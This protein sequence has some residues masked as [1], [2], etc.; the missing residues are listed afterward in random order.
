M[1]DRR[2]GEF[3]GREQGKELGE[4]LRACR[5]SRKPTPC[6]GEHDQFPV[7]DVERIPELVPTVS[8]LE[9]GVEYG[10]SQH[11]RLAAVS[12][13]AGLVFRDQSHY[14]GE[15][16]SGPFV[17]PVR[18]RR[19]RPG[20]GSDAIVPDT[21]GKHDDGCFD[22]G[23]RVESAFDESEVVRFQHGVLP[24]D[25]G[26]P[27]LVYGKLELVRE[28]RPRFGYS[29][30]NLN[31]RIREEVPCQIRRSD[32]GGRTSDHY[33][34]GFL[35]RYGPRSSSG[36]QQRRGAPPTPPPAPPFI[37][38]LTMFVWTTGLLM[39]I[40]EAAFEAVVVC[41]LPR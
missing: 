1:E 25:E 15:D 2:D 11:L 41:E 26:K 16:G 20:N 4:H 19:V 22:L 9:H 39:K 27:P 35:E 24:G 28:N 33:E 18:V 40:P 7:S 31:P 29:E 10:V 32:K 34:H 5:E 8:R 36:F 13:H 38:Y 12:E 3:V 21:V 17:E 23:Q 14:A 30:K 37:V 6:R